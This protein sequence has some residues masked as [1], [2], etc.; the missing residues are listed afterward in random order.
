M[1]AVSALALS[2]CAAT[3]PPDPEPAQ[4]DI[5]WGDEYDGVLF[6]TDVLDAAFAR[7]ASWGADALLG[8][9]RVVRTRANA[10]PARV[11]YRESEAGRAGAVSLGGRGWEV[12]MGRVRPSLADGALLADARD[13]GNV[14][15]RATRRVD[16]LRVSPSSSTWGSSLG[17]GAQARLGRW[18]ATAAAWR[19]PDL[20][21]APDAWSSLSVQG[22]RWKTGVAAGHGGAGGTAASL[23]AARATGAAFVAGEVGVAADGPRVSAR[24]VIGERGE[25]RARAVAGA[26]SGSAASA[27]ATTVRRWGGGVERLSRVGTVTMRSRFTTRI[28]ADDADQSRRQRIEWNARAGVAGGSVESGVRWT[29]EVLDRSPDLLAAS[30]SE[31]A[32]TELRVRTQVT[33]ARNW[34]DGVRAEQR[35]RVDLVTTGAGVGRVVGWSGRLRVTRFDARVQAS[36]YDLGSGQL[37]W[38]GRAVLPGSATFAT[39]SRSGVDLSAALTVSLGWGVEAGIQGLL[40]ARNEHRVV[41]R[42][43]ACG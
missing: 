24:A 30:G 42:V 26:P 34:G 43:A 28:R 35:W 7:D 13:A 5:A 31:P 27:P 39:L 41:F 37:A 23:F 16:G 12:V 33:T 40:N 38:A 9:T 3:M 10:G 19:V 11:V 2:G 21:Q 1:A 17:G 29:R 36:A 15:P 4:P 32:R 20:E 14:D 6:D 25:W 22:A 18:S 8:E